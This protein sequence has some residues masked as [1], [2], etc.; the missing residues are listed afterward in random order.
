MSI[1]I[2]LLWC[3]SAVDPASAEQRVLVGESAG[4]HSAA[5]S[6]Q[7]GQSTPITTSCADKEFPR[8]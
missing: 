5:A 8:R 7:A 4:P 2:L 1:K 6:E 3:V